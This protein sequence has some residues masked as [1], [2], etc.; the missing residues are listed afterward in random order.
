MDFQEKRL[1]YLYGAPSPESR[2]GG[3]EAPKISKEK[4]KEALKKATHEELNKL[5]DELEGADEKG[6]FLEDIAENYAKDLQKLGFSGDWKGLVEFNKAL[7]SNISHVEH[8]PSKGARKGQLLHYHYEREKLYVPTAEAAQLLSAKRAEKVQPKKEVLNREERIEDYRDSQIDEA[9]DIVEKKDSDQWAERVRHRLKSTEQLKQEFKSLKAKLPKYLQ[10]GQAA[11]DNEQWSHLVEMAESTQGDRLIKVIGREPLGWEPSTLRKALTSGRG[12]D[13]VLTFEDIIG[14]THG[15]LNDEFFDKYAELNAAIKNALTSED[16]LQAALKDFKEREQVMV[17]AKEII[18]ALQNIQQEAPSLL[19]EKSEGAQLED[20][21]TQSENITYNVETLYNLD[22]L[23]D[24]KNEVVVEGEVDR[25][26]GILPD[27][28]SQMG[29]IIKGFH[30]DPRFARNVNEGFTLSMLTQAY[31]LEQLIS[32]KNVVK[33]P[34]GTFVLTRIPSDFI[35]RGQDLIKSVRFNKGNLEFKK[36]IAGDMRIE[37]MTKAERTLEIAEQAFSG[38]VE[39]MAAA[40]ASRAWENPYARGS[41]NYDDLGLVDIDAERAFMDLLMQ[42][43]TFDNQGEATLN[44]KELAKDIEY[45]L[46]TGIDEMLKN[47]RLSLSKELKIAGL[48]PMSKEDQDYTERALLDLR[49]LAEIQHRAQTQIKL[50]KARLARIRERQEE[51][52]KDNKK[53]PPHQREALKN[54]PQKIAELQKVIDSEQANI[55]R[56]ESD[57]INTKRPYIQQLKAALQIDAKNLS[58]L[59]SQQIRF[60]QNGYNERGGQRLDNYD[61]N[62]VEQIASRYNYVPGIGQ[63]LASLP[64]SIQ[65][66]PEALGDAAQQI[67]EGLSHMELTPR[68][69]GSGGGVMDV[70]ATNGEVT[71]V[72][73]GGGFNVKLKDGSNM[74]IGFA[75]DILQGGAQAVAGTSASLA[76]NPQGT[77]SYNVSISA[78]PGV[79]ADGNAGALGTITQTINWEAGDF[80]LFLGASTGAG[81]NGPLAAGIFGFKQRPETVFEDARAVAAN[82]HGLGYIDQQTG[83]NRVEAIRQHPLLSNAIEELTAKGYPTEVQNVMLEAMFQ[84]MKEDFEEH[85][86]ANAAANKPTGIQVV[87]PVGSPVPFVMISFMFRGRSKLIYVTKTKQELLNEASNNNHNSLLG[88]LNQNNIFDSNE[89]SFRSA[90]KAWSAKGDRVNLERSYSFSDQI[91]SLRA[92]NINNVNAQLAKAGMSLEQGQ[93][94]MNRM[95]KLNINELEEITESTNLEVIVDPSSKI[96]LTHKPG[97]DGNPDEIYL[98]FDDVDPNADLIIERN[99]MLM[100]LP[101]GGNHVVTQIVIKDNPARRSSDVVDDANAAIV[102]K[103]NSP[104]RVLGEDGTQVMEY[105]QFK[106]GGD[107]ALNA[108]GFDRFTGDLARLKRIDTSQ[109]RENLLDP[110][111]ELEQAAMDIFKKNPQKWAAE[112]MSNEEWYSLDR[113]DLI[114]E[115]MSEAGLDQ[116]DPNLDQ[117][118]SFVLSV[119]RNQTYLNRPEGLKANKEFMAKTL[120]NELFDGDVALATEIINEIEES[121]LTQKYLSDTAEMFVVAGR[122]GQRGLRRDTLARQTPLENFTTFGLRADLEAKIIEALTPLP[123][124]D[125]AFLQTTTA[126]NAYHLYPFLKSVDATNLLTAIY[127]NPSLISSSPEHQAAFTEFKQLVTDLDAAR[128]DGET[129]KIKNDYGHEF[130]V[131]LRTYVFGG[132]LEKC[133]NTTLGIDERIFVAGVDVESSNF[134]Q[135]VAGADRELYTPYVEIG[136]G[137]RGQNSSVERVTTGGGD[138]DDDTPPDHTDPETGGGFEDITLKEAPTDQS[139]GGQSPF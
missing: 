121:N 91:D 139:S 82:E 98:R 53:L 110:S 73:M 44:S 95:F 33:N 43:R 94:D 123:E 13:H 47:P 122:F 62:T 131:G 58:T 134:L 66:D 125:E 79:S 36:Q 63:I 86:E 67:S 51:L 107:E 138:D 104:M 22:A 96:A 70:G 135:N 64:E 78:G 69:E 115:I 12:L 93:D 74:H 90:P 16:Q 48:P 127:D 108:L 14:I 59:S 45:F 42:N 11:M 65:K 56:I 102:R 24:G 38:G 27:V 7:G 105:K 119:I 26:I 52:E 20:Q 89:F 50:P 81:V 111:G 60:I 80:D 84:T 77:A 118:V 49:D 92:G 8:T 133:N 109:V 2:G 61:E 88:E 21:T 35:T 126:L 41:E 113:T 83:A 97:K 54:L 37:G 31:G 72:K 29:D 117:K 137:G 75:G 19:G 120:A 116:T 85:G 34:D 124:S 68:S 40:D 28:V 99:T 71:S 57:L 128:G 6:K 30:E 76:L 103:G 101:D 39:R 46:S 130:Y 23:L 136:A 10:G 18:A 114:G 129:F 3:S 106:E 87:W 55:V 17:Q 132:N 15:E 5:R 112:S 25:S 1:I 100:P 4:A 9:S 32:D